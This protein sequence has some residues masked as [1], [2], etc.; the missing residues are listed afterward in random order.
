MHCVFYLL[1]DVLCEDRIV[2]SSTFCY[3]TLLVLHKFIR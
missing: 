1:S 3:T 2:I